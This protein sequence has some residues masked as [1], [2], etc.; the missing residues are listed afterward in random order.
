[1][2]GDTPHSAEGEKIR[3]VSGEEDSA[4]R[5]AIPAT[6]ILERR[7]ITRSFWSLPSWYLHTVA[8]GEHLIASGSLSSG[9]GTA[10]GQSENG[11]LFAWS[12][13]EVMLYKDAC[14]RYWHALIGDKPLV[15]VICRDDADEVD[16]ANAN[17]LTLQPITVTVDYDDASASAETDSPVLSAPIPSE[18]YRYMERFVLT[19]YQPQ[20]FKKRKRRNWSDEQGQPGQSGR[21]N[22]DGRAKGPRDE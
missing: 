14:E 8:I 1:M 19:H 3:Q 5:L 6:V 11:D 2:S 20:E 22:A 4:I 16:G 10:A 7:M 21:G 15:Y 18:L 13:F 12:G 17:A 9:N